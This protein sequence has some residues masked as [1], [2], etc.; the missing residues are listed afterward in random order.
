MNENRK[1]TVSTVLTHVL[2]LILVVINPPSHD[3]A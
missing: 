1:F 2:L 3:I